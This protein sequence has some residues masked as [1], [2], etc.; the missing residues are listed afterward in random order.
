[1]G[2]EACALEK[3]LSPGNHWLGSDIEHELICYA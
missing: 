1:M 2:T 3:E